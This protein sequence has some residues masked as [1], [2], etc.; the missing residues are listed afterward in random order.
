MYPD[1]WEHFLEPIPEVERCDMM[2]AYHRRLT[3][4]DPEVQLKCAQRWSAWE[5]ATSRL[6]Q[7]HDL[8]KRAEKDAWALQFARIE[9]HY[10]VNGG[11]LRSDT[12][13]LDDVEKIRHIPCT[14]VQ[15]RYDVVCPPETAWALHKKWPES[16]LKF[17]SDAGHS[18]KEVGIVSALVEATDKY[19]TL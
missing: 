19:K 13:V 2:S 1:T 11:F 17:I 10:F 7:D 5:M 6:I 12:H 14:I 3:G 4:T 8:I 18:A 9:V 15:G 16:E